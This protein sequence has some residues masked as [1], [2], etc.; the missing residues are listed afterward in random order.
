MYSVCR[1]TVSKYIVHRWTIYRWTV[2]KSTVYRYTMNMYSVY[3]YVQC[4]CEH[5]SSIE[6]IGIKC[7]QCTGEQFP[8]LHNIC[9][10]CTGEQLKKIYSVQDTQC[11]V[12]GDGDNVCPLGGDCGKVFGHTP[13][14][15]ML[16]Q[17]LDSPQCTVNTVHYTLYTTQC[18]LHTVY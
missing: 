8:S 13:W 3:I 18:T 12:P 14:H 10:Q 6:C 5:L 2:S 11:T 15:C 1:C 4:K 7:K 16:C 9:K 17:G